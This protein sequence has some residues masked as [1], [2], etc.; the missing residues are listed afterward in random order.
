MIDRKERESE[1]KKKSGM[2]TARRDK[3]SKRKE[4]CEGG[5]AG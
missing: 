1:R 2:W 5:K 4:G 3:E